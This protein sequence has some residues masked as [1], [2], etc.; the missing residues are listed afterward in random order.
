MTDSISAVS[1]SATS[2]TSSSSSSSTKLTDATKAQLEAL[3]ID[4]TNITTEADGQAAL[5]AAEANKET[6][7]MS[8]A[9]NPSEDSIKTDAKSLAS[10]LGV[11]ISDD[12]TT[13]DILD[14][15]S[16]AISQLREAAG[17]DQTKLAEV[18]KYQDEYDTISGDY[19]NMQTSQAQ[20]TNSMS[21]LASYNKIYQNLS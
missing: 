3:G 1:A 6:A 4:T 9:S 20:L 10:E 7:K 12:D 2:N 5:K 15:I 11:S 21:G 14:K 17:D 13:D 16:S 18:E 19:T 8:Q